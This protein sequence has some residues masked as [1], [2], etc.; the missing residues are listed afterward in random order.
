MLLAKPQTFMNV[1]G[2]SVVPLMRFYRVPPSRLLVLYDDLDIDVAALRLRKQGSHGGH[3][4][5]R[6]II[7][8]LG[9]DAAFPRLRIGI[10]RPKG[11]TPVASHVLTPFDSREAA[12]IE[13]TLVQAVAAVRSVLADGIDKAMNA[14]GAAASGKQ[15]AAKQAAGGGGARGPPAG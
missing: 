9:G 10:G 11:S 6:S 1:S 2:E 12:E 4:G 5:M 3:N 13:V 7:E 15:P 8:Q 14:V